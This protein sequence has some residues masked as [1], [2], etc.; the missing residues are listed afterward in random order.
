VDMSDI[1][2]IFCWRE[3][4]LSVSDQP[5]ATPVPMIHISVQFA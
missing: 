3:W 4:R 2:N 5:V 1:V